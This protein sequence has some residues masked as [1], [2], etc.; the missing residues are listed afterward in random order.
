MTNSD[1][2]DSINDIILDGFNSEGLAKLEWYA[3]QVINRKILFKRFSP[4]EQ[5]GCSEGGSTHVIATIL[6]GAKNQPNQF[7]EGLDEP[8]RMFEQGEKQAKTIEVW[9]KKEGIWFDDIDNAISSRLGERIAE[10]GEAKVYDNGTSLLKTIGLDYFILPI[11]ALDRISL[12]NAYFP[13][14]KMEVIGFGRDADGFFKILITQPFIEGMRMSDKEIRLFMSNMGFLL[15][16]P[17]NW[18]Y[19]TPEI[20]LSDMHD[21]NILKSKSGT[22]FVIDCDIRLNTPDLKKGGIRVFTNEI[23]WRLPIKK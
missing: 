18:T 3:T 5:H 15:Q 9:A 7:S 14:T 20:Y 22:I 2:W 10:G 19:V 17:R 21:E 4:Q 23:I 11:L 13:E 6:A 1:F 12:H 8:K 16:N